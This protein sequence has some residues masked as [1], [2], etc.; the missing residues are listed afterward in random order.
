MMTI[1]ASSSSYSTKTRRFEAG[2]VQR[3]TLLLL[4]CFL[5]F[6]RVPRLS[7]VPTVDFA[8]RRALGLSRPA[9]TLAVRHSPPFPGRA[10]YEASQAQ[11]ISHFLPFQFLCLIPPEGFFV[12][13]HKVDEAGARRGRQDRPSLRAHPALR[14]LPG[15]IFTVRRARRAC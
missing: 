7:S 5:L 13:A 8:R 9:G 4:P 10:L 6:D 14:L 15:R 2:R 11:V 3:H 12:P 1:P